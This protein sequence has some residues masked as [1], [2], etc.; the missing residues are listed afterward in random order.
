MEMILAIAI[1]VLGGSG[2]WLVLRG[3]SFFGDAFVHGVL[4]GIASAVVFGF[5]PYL[6]AAVAAL[7][8]H[9]LA[10]VGLILLIL[11]HIYLAFWV[12]GSIRGMVTG[13]VSHA[14]ARAHHD[15]W[16]EEISAKPAAAGKAKTGSTR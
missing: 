6:G 1:G 9:A 8:L 4:P 14:W 2:V 12:K 5:S 10:G 7:A 3:M 11:G 16:H 13:Y 15:R